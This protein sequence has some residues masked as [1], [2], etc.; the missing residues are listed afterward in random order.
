MS[1]RICNKVLT[2]I[3]LTEL[4]G[5]FT[6]FMG[7]AMTLSKKKKLIKGIQIGKGRVKLFLDDM[8]VCIEY[9]KEST[10]K[11]LEQTH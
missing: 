6:V 7:H 4:W 11:L 5:S 1:E 9:P 8:I 2:R 10:K 3:T